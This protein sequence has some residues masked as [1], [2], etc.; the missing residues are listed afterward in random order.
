MARS[1]A[2]DELADTMLEKA[3]EQE[4]DPAELRDAVYHAVACMMG[5]PRGVMAMMSV[6]MGERGPELAKASGAGA[7]LA[8]LLTMCEMHGLVVNCWRLRAEVDRLQAL[9]AS[10]EDQ[11][12]RAGD[13]P[14]VNLEA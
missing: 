2:T 14:A 12:V 1:K 8:M 9:V 3:S 4:H 10:L 6:A 11:L 13:A 7:E 5:S